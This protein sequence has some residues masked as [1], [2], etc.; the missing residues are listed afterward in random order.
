MEPQGENKSEGEVEVE[1]ESENHTTD[2]EKTKRM[3][4]ILNKATIVCHSISE[5]NGML[6]P[7]ELFMNREIY[8]NLK[9][10]IPDLKSLFSSSY[11]TSLQETAE[12]KQ[13]WPLLNLLRQV[14]RSCNFKLTPK[15]I[16][17]GYSIDGKK[18]YKRMFIIEKMRVII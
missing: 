2:L 18:K 14:L 13:K 16:S 1:S 8:K 11:L 9:G 5:I 3:I 12:K 15:R 7:R 10:T 6:V 4:E 17:D